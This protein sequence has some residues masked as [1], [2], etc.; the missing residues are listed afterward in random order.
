ML[1]VSIA[2][3]IVGNQIGKSDTQEC[4]ELF[5]EFI[6]TNNSL[7]SLNLRGNPDLSTH[8]NILLKALLLNDTVSNLDITHFA[9]DGEGVLALARFVAKSKSIRFLKMEGVFLTGNLWNMFFR[10]IKKSCTV[11]TLNISGPISSFYQGF[12]TFCDFIAGNHSFK[13]L[14]IRGVLS[15]S[16][17]DILAFCKAIGINTT[18]ENLVVTFPENSDHDLFVSEMKHFL[19]NSSL[20]RISLGIAKW[21]IPYILIILKHLSTNKTLKYVSFVC[22]NISEDPSLTIEEY[23]NVVRWVS[24]NSV[25]T[26]ISFNYRFTE[27]KKAIDEG[28]SGLRGNHFNWSKSDKD[29]GFKFV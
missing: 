25:I 1:D 27:L 23:E 2:F 7:K 5:G 29:L 16:S 28:L 8:F 11:H 12:E 20:E 21:D 10:G 18:L 3:L 26:S 19:S 15:E 14:W 24:R 22:A 9:L 13:S 4:A 6:A 17:Q